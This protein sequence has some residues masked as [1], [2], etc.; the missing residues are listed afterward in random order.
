MTNIE[1][2]D[3][4]GNIICSVES[5]FRIIN[6]KDLEKEKKERKRKSNKRS[7]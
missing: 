5:F 6:T 2:K 3:P 1:I 4:N 7:Y